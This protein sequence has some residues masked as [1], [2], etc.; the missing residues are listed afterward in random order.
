[1][2]THYLKNHSRVNR[3]MFYVVRQLQV[4]LFGLPLQI[5]AFLLDTALPE[6]EAVA[7]SIFELVFITLPQFG[8]HPVQWPRISRVEGYPTISRVVPMP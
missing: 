3:D 1:M 5:T 8:L 7:A 6:Y 2:C 4:E